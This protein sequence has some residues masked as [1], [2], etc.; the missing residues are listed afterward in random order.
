[1]SVNTS[2]VWPSCAVPTLLLFYYCSYL[3]AWPSCAGQRTAWRTSGRSSSRNNKGYLH[4]TERPG[5]HRA[6]SA[7]LDDPYHHNPHSAVG[8]PRPLPPCPSPS[9]SYTAL[10]YLLCFLVRVLLLLLF[11]KVGGW[12]GGWVG[13]CGWLVGWLIVCLFGWLVNLP[14][15]LNVA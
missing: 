12:V 15:L 8:C 7:A 11:A 14:A 5:A 6:A 9:A 1:M 10:V 4:R 2:A 13:G 3:A